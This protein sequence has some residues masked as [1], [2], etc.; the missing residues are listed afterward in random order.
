MQKIN[1][2][3]NLVKLN[4]QFSNDAT[5]RAYLERLRWPNGLACLRC[6]NTTV[7]PIKHRGQYHCPACTYQFSVTTGTVMQDTHLPLGKWFLATYLML[8]S[9]KGISANQ[10]KRTLCIG[11]QTAWYLCHRIRAAMAELNPEPLRGTVEVDETFVGGKV[12]GKGRGYRGNKAI[13]VGAI[14]RQGPIRLKVVKDTTRKTLHGFIRSTTAPDTEAI[15]TDEWPAY[16]GIG[17][18]DTRHET[19]N[20]SADEWVRGQVHTNTIESVWSLLDRSIIGA[21]HHVSVKHI[22]AYVDELEWRFSNRENPYLF[23]DTL[24]KLLTSERLEY[25]TLV[26]KAV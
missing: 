20:H 26:T 1:Q 24:T 17:D 16:R 15:Y 3:M 6:G 21:Y 5:C 14:Q 4:A 9:R 13:V 10:M 22:D 7:Y 11:Y 18:K 2:D 25:K 12:Q 19:V 23:R 8:E